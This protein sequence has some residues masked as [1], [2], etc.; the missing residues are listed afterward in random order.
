MTALVGLTFGFQPEIVPS[1]V[2]KRNRA[3]P[4]VLPCVITKPLVPLKT[5]PVGVPGPEPEA[6]GMLTTRGEPGGNGLPLP[7]YS[8]ETPV[9]LSETQKGL[10]ELSEI[11]QGLT[12]W[13]SVKA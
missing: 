2:S 9:P 13:G 3:G 1:S 11:P 5:V 8:V 12:R 6:C 10:E 4:D 7:L